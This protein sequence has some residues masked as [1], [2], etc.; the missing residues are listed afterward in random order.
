MVFVWPTSLQSILHGKNLETV[1]TKSS[2]AYRHHRLLP[3]STTCVS[4]TTAEGQWKTKRGVIFSHISQL[5]RMKFVELNILMLLSDEIIVLREITAAL[6]I[7]SNFLEFACIQMFLNHPTGYDN[8]CYLT[9]H[10]HACV[11]ALDHHLRPQ[12]CLKAKNV[13]TSYLTEFSVNWTRLWN[14]ADACCS[15]EPHFHFEGST[16]MVYLKHDM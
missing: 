6:L 10:F 16:R 14:A 3:F 1:Q 8:R 11:S 2:M 12:E 4:L 15:Y 13:C 5:I 9:L 7:V